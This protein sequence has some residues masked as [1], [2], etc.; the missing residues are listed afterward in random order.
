MKKIPV[1]ILGATGLVGKSYLKLLKNHPQFEVVFLASSERMVGEKPPFENLVLDS[2][3]NIEK[4]AKSCR[5]IFSALPPHA[6]ILFEEKYAKAGLRVISSSSIHRLSSDIPMI[7]PEVN[8]DHLEVL[9]AQQKNR[10]FHK[11]FIVTK[12]NCTLQSYLLPLFPLHL[13]FG[14]K[15][16]LITSMQALSGGGASV[17]SSEAAGNITPYI[18]GEEEKSEIEPLKILGAI[19]SGNI[20]P[21][22]NIQI[23]AHCNRVPVID[24]HL[25]TVSASF[26]GK[27]SLSEIV[28]LWESFKGPPQMQSLVS[29]PE[30]P[31]IYHPLQDRPQPILDRQS[32]EGMSVTVGRLRKC[33]VLDI[34]F[35]SLSHN[36]IRGAAGGGVLI[37]EQIEASNYG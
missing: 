22:T 35:V 1:G 23:S 37:A 5:Y 10:G 21:A 24:G 7:I 3:E 6:A 31:I 33:P 17:V 11:G 8:S 4:A 28:S 18:E 27:F 26:H 2:C 36:I 30:K 9:R 19:E 20:K 13:A 15:K 32:G 34:K 14:L 12:P 25:T 29:A 16:L